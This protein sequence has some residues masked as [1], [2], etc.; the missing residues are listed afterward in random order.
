MLALTLIAIYCLV[1]FQIVHSSAGG[2]YSIFHPRAS[3][4]FDKRLDVLLKSYIDSDEQVSDKVKAEKETKTEEDII[5]VNLEY[6][7]SMSEL[8][9]IVNR[10]FSEAESIIEKYRRLLVS[11]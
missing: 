9:P 11:I 5:D 1:N 7:N 10:V 3:K 4:K 8:L 6:F 2:S